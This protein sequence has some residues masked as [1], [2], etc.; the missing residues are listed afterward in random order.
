MSKL[1]IAG[2]W[3]MNNTVEA[4]EQLVRAIEENL[5]STIDVEV[6]LC[7]PF[8]S[9]SKVAELTNKNSIK[10]G[11]QNVYHEKKGAFT[12]E[13]S[14][15]MIK[16]L[17]E[18]VII[19]HSE[20]R[21]ILGET[22]KIINMKITAAINE[23]LNIILCVGET[24]EQRERGKTQEIIREQLTESLSDIQRIENITIA[25]EPVWAI[26]TGISAST[27]D[28]KNGI[29]TIRSILQEMY[30]ELT[31]QSTKILYGGSVNPQNIEALLREAGIDGGLIGG[32]SLN[33]ESFVSIINKSNIF[34]QKTGSN[35]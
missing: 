14:P 18:Y 3:K 2:N 31:A 28:C 29:E 9:L 26:G 34:S 23:G 25:Y 4:A 35:D 33:A 27:M 8:T 10:V 15:E 21:L 12:G 11:A 32:A 22:N 6:I 30:G 19:G 24:L 5:E 13:I 16:E 20:R 1:V 7:P 17:C